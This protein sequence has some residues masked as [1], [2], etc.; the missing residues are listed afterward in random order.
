MIETDDIEEQLIGRAQFC[1]D[2]GEEKTP[3]LMRLAATEIRVLRAMVDDHNRAKRYE[4][5]SI[6][7]AAFVYDAL[8]D[9]LALF[10]SMD[11]PTALALRRIIEDSHLSQHGPIGVAVADVLVQFS[12]GR[13]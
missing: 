8:M 7:D 10:R 11:R 4:P 9:F 5:G 3:R 1:I 2:R 13:G 6:S 12:P